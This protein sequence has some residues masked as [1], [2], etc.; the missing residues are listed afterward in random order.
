MGVR[1]AVFCWHVCMHVPLYV[2]AY[3]F[4][5]LRQRAEVPRARDGT[6][7]T[8]VTMPNPQPTKPPGNSQAKAS[9]G[10]GAGVMWEHIPEKPYRHVRRVLHP[11]TAGDLGLRMSFQVFEGPLLQPFP[12]LLDPDL[13]DFTWNLTGLA[14]LAGLGEICF[15]GPCKL[16][17]PHTQ[18]GK[19]KS[20]M[21][22]EVSRSKI[23]L[24]KCF[25]CLSWCHVFDT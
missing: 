25:N 2:Y 17:N 14:F 12:D 18:K 24:T 3:A 11:Q 7:A 13:F 23:L 6:C 15:Q 19:G 22:L 4:W 8:V 21:P 5:P 20:I 16:D 1:P 9:K 10:W